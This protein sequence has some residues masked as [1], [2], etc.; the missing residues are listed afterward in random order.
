MRISHFAVR[1]PPVIG[2][3]LIVLIAFGLYAFSG[4]NIEFMADISLP[5]VEVLA[6]YPGSTAE[7]VETD[8]TDVLERSFV[9]LPNFKAI[10]SVSNNTFSWITITFQDGIDPYDMLDEIRNRIRQLESQLPDTLQGEPI[11]IVGSAN[12]LPVYMFSVAAGT[13]TVRLSEYVESTLMPRL[14]RINGVAE[15]SITGSQTME[16]QITMRNS[17]L[18]S[19]GISALQVFQVLQYA[20]LRL[21]LGH[22]DYRGMQANLRY[23]GSLSSLKELE[24]LPIG[25]TKEGTIIRLGNVADVS[26]ALKE[27]ESYADAD[28]QSRIVVSVTKRTDGNT[29]RIAREIRKVLEQARVETGGAIEYQILS[30]DSRNVVSSLK[31]VSQSGLTGMLMAI[32]VIFLF[33]SDS[34]ATLTIALSIPLSILFTF[35]GMRISGITINLMSLSGIVVALGMV[36]DGSI[37]MLEQVMRLHKREGLDTQTALLKGSDLVGAPIL[38]STTTTVA[39]FIPLSMLSGIVGS[40]L[41]DVALTLILALVASLLVALVVVPFILRLLLQV[42]QRI[43]IQDPLFTRFLAALERSYRAALQF[44]LSNRKFI[45]F[46]AVMLL[47]LALLIAGMLGITF[48]P[49]TDNGDFNIDLEFP[50][51]YSLE[52]TRERALVAQ[53]L[54]SES[55]EEIQSIVLFSGKSSSLGFSSPNQA[56][57][58]VVLKPTSERKRSVHQI[59]NEVQQLLSDSLVD[60]KVRT[61]NGGFDALVGY[62]AGGGGYG[63]KLVGEDIFEL[64]ETA[65]QIRQ[66]LAQDNEVLSTNINTSY[67]ANTLVIDMSHHLMSNLGV[68]SSEAGLTASL[69][70]YGMEVGTLH[71]KAGDRFPIRLA[72]DLKDLPITSNTLLNAKVPSASGTLISFSSLASLRTER[73]ISRIVRANRAKTV[74]VSATLVSEDTKGVHQRVQEYLSQNPLPET[75]TSASGGLMELIRDSIGPMA[76]ALIIAIFLVYTVMVIQFERFRQPLIVM[77]SIPFSLIGVILGLLLFGSSI[78]LISFMAVI[79]LGGIVVNNGIIL[80]DSINVLRQDRNSTESETIQDLREAVVDGGSTR[81]RPI[82]M[83]TLT[84]MLGVIPMAF[85]KGEGSAIYAPLGQAIAGGLFSS[86]LITLFIIP[87]LYYMTE[88]RIIRKREKKEALNV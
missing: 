83:T 9:T 65:E 17:D 14:T 81:L 25:S 59:I 29:L 70:F 6:V 31:K 73:A 46:V 57:I 7:D 32:V 39:V 5:T 37:V 67:D 28:G 27:Q 82:L 52:Q 15:A 50:Q 41:R 10:D 64:H 47:S 84:T 8:V 21:P 48:I 35:I 60:T 62:I 55:V 24:E 45:L 86:T 40:I 74:T 34:R 30:D 20:N 11:A 85:A 72:S 44:G 12:M 53:R 19:T 54:V 77:A 22:A 61:T 18:N 68:S 33:L 76:T 71:T 26:L 1:H 58:R 88:R 78:S 36:V 66:F 2:M 23:D 4:L 79:A 56:S 42:K 16:V 38:A 69:L 75:V 43:R 49:S 51:G 80:I 87:I 3:L 63:L 13:D